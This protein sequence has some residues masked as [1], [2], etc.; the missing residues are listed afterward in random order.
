MDGLEL[1]ESMLVYTLKIRNLLHLMQKF[2]GLVEKNSIDELFS[3]TEFSSFVVLAVSTVHHL[4]YSDTN[5][6]ATIKI[7][8]DRFVHQNHRFVECLYCFWCGHS[9]M[10]PV[11]WTFLLVIWPLVQDANEMYQSQSMALSINAQLCIL[12]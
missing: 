1:I 7:S 10:W 5:D 6:N 9:W 2:I 3:F 11:L 8:L 12:L 4:P